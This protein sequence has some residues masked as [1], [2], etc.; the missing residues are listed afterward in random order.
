MTPWWVVA[1]VVGGSLTLVAC[2]RLRPYD[3][4]QSLF[5]KDLLS[6]LLLYGLLQSYLLGLLIEHAVHAA[7]R[8]GLSSGAGGGLGR[9]LG[10]GIGGW[11]LAGQLAFF[12]V[13]HDFYIYWFHRLQHASPWLW[14]L[15]EAHHSTRQVDWISG[16]RSHA[17]EILINQ[18][19][20]LAP[21]VLLHAHPTVAPLKLV[22]SVLWGM[23][24]HGN[25]DTRHGRWLY[26][27]NG[28]E[29]HRWHH[30]VETA[31][32]NVNFGTK[33]AVWDWVF[34]TASVP[35]GTKPGAYGLVDPGFPEGF[36]RQ[37][38]HVFAR[39]PPPF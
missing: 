39:R 33:L 25:W 32:A 36:L 7:A 5:R 23:Y 38:A 13:T 20:E 29:M 4:R 16:A 31:A 30:A 9:A 28:P 6:D 11:P 14:R 12:V 22:A 19:V 3:S 2:E 37:Q 10:S 35:T 1:A 26:L 21:I 34:G 24:I 15:H 27:F 8:T 18:T 17:F